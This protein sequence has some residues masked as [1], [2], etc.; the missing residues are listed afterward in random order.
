MDP[1]NRTSLK[2]RACAR[3][4]FDKDKKITIAL[5][6]F[7]DPEIV[8]KF[9]DG[10]KEILE[11]YPLIVIDRNGG[12]ALKEYASFYRKTC[13]PT[14]GLPLG[15]SRGFLIG[16][17][18]T[19]FTLNLDVDVLLPKHFVKESLKKFEDP[20]VA[21]VALDYENLQG[22]LAFGPSIWR[23]EILQNLYDWGLWKT[24]KCECIYMWGKVRGAKY[25]VETLG[26]RAKHLRSVSILIGQGKRG[27]LNCSW[28]I[29]SRLYTRFK[30]RFLV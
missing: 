24:R 7:E 26:M 20:K 18:E 10:N 13:C 8:A 9:I 25:K 5:P 2:P 15:S 23:T 19:E 30:R 29:L 4:H 17:V 1:K 28:N 11:K 21:V 3:V 14:I 16:R 27:F 12:E 6:V 22:H